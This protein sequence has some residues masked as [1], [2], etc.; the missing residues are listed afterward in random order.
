[1]RP[2]LQMSE[3]LL[4]SRI[5]RPHHLTTRRFSALSTPSWSMINVRGPTTRSKA[6]YLKKSGES[7]GRNHPTNLQVG[8]SVQRSELEGL[9]TVSSRL[10]QQAPF[11]LDHLA[12]TRGTCVR[13]RGWGRELSECLYSELKLCTARSRPYDSQCLPRRTFHV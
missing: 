9:V 10:P 13:R 12:R 5:C 2:P 11:Y 4:R 6:I 1:M 7:Y 3:L 8:R